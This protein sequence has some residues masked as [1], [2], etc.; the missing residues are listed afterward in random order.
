M[1]GDDEGVVDLL[2]A[3]SGEEFAG[4]FDLSGNAVFV[5]VGL[6]AAADGG[7][8]DGSQ[9]SSL[10]ASASRATVA[11][12]VASSSTLLLMFSEGIERMV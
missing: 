8:D 12:P 2:P 10:A 6:G 3:L 11:K 9:D 4:G 7:P 5:I 1:A